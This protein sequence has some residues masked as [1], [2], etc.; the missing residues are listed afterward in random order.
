MFFKKYKLFMPSFEESSE[1]LF[2]VC[3]FPNGG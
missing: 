2:A 3:Q 1:N